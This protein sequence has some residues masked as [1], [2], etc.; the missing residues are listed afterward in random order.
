MLKKQ[1]QMF[2]TNVGI[3]NIYKHDKYNIWET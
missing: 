1:Q 2:K 3:F